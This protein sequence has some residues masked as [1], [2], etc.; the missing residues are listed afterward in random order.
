MERVD[1]RT[2][3]MDVPPQDVITKDNV[4]VKVNAVLYFRVVDPR[5]RHRRGGRLSSSPPRSWRRRRCAA[6]AARASSTSCSPARE[7]DQPAH[8]GDPRHADRS[9]G[10]QG[11]HRSRSST[12]TCRRR[13]SAPWRAQAEAERERRAKVINAEGEFQA[14]QKLA[15]ASAII[16]QHPTALQLRFLQT[17]AE[18]ASEH[19]STTIFPLPIDLLQPFLAKH[20]RRRRAEPGGAAPP[21]ATSH[22]ARRRAV[23]APRADERVPRRLRRLR[24]RPAAGADRADASRRARRGA[25]AGA[26]PRRAPRCGTPACAIC[27]SCCGAGDLLV[28]NDTRVR[29]ARLHCRTASGGA[30]ELLVVARA[31]SRACGAVSAARPSACA[32]DTALRPA[33][34][35]ARRSSSARTDA[36][37]YAV[38][39]AGVRRRGAAGPPRRA[40]AAAV[41]QAP[42]RSV[43]AR[44]RALPDRLRRAR[45]R[46][47]R[48]DGGPALQP[49]RC[50][51][52]STR[53]ACS[54]P[55]LTLHVGPGTFLPVRSDD[56]REHRMEPEWAELPAATAAA[57]AR[58]KA[59]R[60]PRHRRRHDHDAGARV[61]APRGGGAGRAACGPTPSSCPGFAFAGRRRAADQLPPAALDAAHAG[62][63]PSPA[64]SASSPRT[65]PP[66]ASGYRF[67]SYGDAMLIC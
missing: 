43:A 54:A 50:S 57:I 63:A 3:T 26:R 46:G 20:G 60:R 8:P 58:T 33:G 18:I 10:H 28:F 45:R 37:R 66:C 30:V 13:C 64:A 19:H 53:R 17:L 6:S 35:Q 29:P 4:S 59:A 2:V 44:P 14:A 65:P 56:V 36:G 48:A 32:P 39:F 9:V 38:E 40:A 21:A 12:S 31:A 41:H 34:W 52:R 22:D 11:R 42:G 23:L 5:P 49:R 16:S 47:R 27:R 51:P 15:E 24:L 61:R 55:T 1:L 67:Y 25:P 62:R 7:R